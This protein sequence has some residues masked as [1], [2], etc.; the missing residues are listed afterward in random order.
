MNKNIFYAV[1]RVNN[2]LQSERG[3]P[4][5][6]PRM[7]GDIYYQDTDRKTHS[8]TAELV[9][10]GY[11]TV[12]TNR[13]HDL[14][15][16][17]E[18]K[19]KKREKEAIAAGLGMH[20]GDKQRA[21]RTVRSMEWLRG[22][23]QNQFGQQYKCKILSG[24]VDGVISGSSLRM[25]L[26]VDKKRRVFKTVVVNLAGVN[27][28]RIPFNASSNYKGRKKKEDDRRKKIERLFGVKA[29]EW[30]EERLLGQRG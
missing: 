17:E 14:G 30:T 27:C 21:E 18:E 24:V 22:Q 25:E 2:N 15:E 29:K 1:W 13:R 19:L 5:R 9:G 12:K 3:Q 23:Q 11:A 28:P 6:E 26:I 10:A 8:L 4:A 7:W 16:K 20:N